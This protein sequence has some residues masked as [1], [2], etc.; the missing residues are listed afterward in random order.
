LISGQ[1]HDQIAKGK[2]AITYL[3]EE[4]LR[5]IGTPVKIYKVV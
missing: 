5:G 3:G 1:V 2:M 4:P